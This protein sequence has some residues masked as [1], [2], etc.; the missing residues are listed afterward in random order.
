MTSIIDCIYLFAGYCCYRNFNLDIMLSNFRC[1]RV[2]KLSSHGLPDSIEQ[3]IHLRLLH[4]YQTTIRELPKSITKLYNLQTLRIEPCNGFTQFSLLEDLSNLIKLR[5]IHIDRISSNNKTHKNMRRLT[6]L[7]TLPYFCVGRDEGYQIKE[8]GPLKNLKGEIDI[9][10]L[11][12]VED[13]EEAKSAKLKEKEI[14]NL[15]LYWSFGRDEDEKHLQRSCEATKFANDWKSRLEKKRDDPSEVVTAIGNFC[16]CS[17]AIGL[18]IE[19]IAIYGIHHRG[20]HVGI[21]KLFVL[22]IMPS[23]LPPHTSSPPAYLDLYGKL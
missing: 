11:E 10:N 13:E 2:L 1:L 9:K 5:H 7:Q 8:L 14:F 20:N 17:I 16:I 3:L 19:I 22:L 21:D 6:C 12:M 15:G 23:L 4:I 18:V